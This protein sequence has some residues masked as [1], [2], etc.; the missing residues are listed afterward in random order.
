MN[1]FYNKAAE[2]RTKVRELTDGTDFFE[3]FS[4]GCFCRFSEIT[5]SFH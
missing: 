5:L 2:N 4:E 1:Y 3:V